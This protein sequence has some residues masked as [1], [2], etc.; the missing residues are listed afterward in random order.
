MQ[1]RAFKILKII[2]IFCVLILFAS[3]CVGGYVL[4]LDY[5]FSDHS[6]VLAD[7]VNMDDWKKYYSEIS[8]PLDTKLIESN[9]ESGQIVSG[10]S[11]KKNLGFYW[12]V[13]SDLSYED[14]LNYFNEK[15]SESND[16]FAGIDTEPDIQPIS[17]DKCYFFDEIEDKIRKARDNYS[18][19]DKV[20]IIY[21]VKMG[22]SI[23]EN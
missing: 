4:L 1:K 7:K 16:L 18:N 23:L 21:A 19:L 13:E 6:D 17:S 15:I 14:L 5:G 12:I 3:I 8:M 2:G 11:D 9:F 10:N 20:W 22:R